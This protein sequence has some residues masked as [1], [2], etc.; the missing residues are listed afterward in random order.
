MAQ[1]KCPNCGREFARRV[2]RT[3]MAELLL[4]YFYVYP[5]KC[6]LCGERFRFFQW[7]VRYV[8]V[9]EDR[10][11]YDRMEMNFPVSFYGQDV[12]GEGSVVNVSMGGCSFRTATK[13][14][15]SAIL[16]LSLQI[17]KEVPPVVV[18]AAM[19]R[20]VRAGTIGVEFLLWQQSERERLQLFVRGLLIGQ[21]V[22]LD[23]LVSRPEPLLPR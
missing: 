6:Q 11:E 1:L 8:R 4:S 19:V 12:S 14:E 9:E 2:S 3:G 5:F 13:V 23:P 22:E 10:R 16:N 21:G 7:G 20:N 17:S 15:T 18:D